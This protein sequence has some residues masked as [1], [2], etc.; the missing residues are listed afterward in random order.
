[1]VGQG[2]ESQREIN[3]AIHLH[4]I[5]SLYFY[6]AFV[7]EMGFALSVMAGSGVFQHSNSTPILMKSIRCLKCCGKRFPSVVAS[8][9][10]FPYALH[11]H[12]YTNEEVDKD[13]YFACVS[14]VF[15]FDVDFDV[16]ISLQNLPHDGKTINIHDTTNCYSMLYM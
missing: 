6:F 8:L 12:T 16:E 10:F 13:I 7:N 2:S 14:L 11:T 4:I 1:M 9:L 3:D 5:T 15:D